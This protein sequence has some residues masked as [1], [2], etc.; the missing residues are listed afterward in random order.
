MTREQIDAAIAKYADQETLYDQPYVD[1][2]RARVSGPFTVEAV[3]A[4]T[5]RSL[6][7][8]ETGS[9]GS[10][11]VQDGQATSLSH[12]PGGWRTP[13]SVS[14]QRSC[15]SFRTGFSERK[16]LKAELFP[17]GAPPFAL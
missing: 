14:P 2:S 10:Q 4:P 9:T 12:Q 7:E 15:A 13:F 11:P 3:P 1:K 5:V 16:L 6:E 17:E 8:I